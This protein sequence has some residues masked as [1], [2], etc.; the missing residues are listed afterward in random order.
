MT[1]T[2]KLETWQPEAD[3]IKLLKT[4]SKRLVALK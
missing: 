3:R 4:Q 2:V 1:T